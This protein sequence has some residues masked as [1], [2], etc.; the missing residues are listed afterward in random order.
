[1]EALRE[2][3]CKESASAESEWANATK[4]LADARVKDDDLRAEVKWRTAEKQAA[5]RAVAEAESRHAIAAAAL[6][7]AE[8]QSITAAAVVAQ[9]QGLLGQL[10]DHEAQLLQQ[11]KLAAEARQEAQETK[12]H[13]K[14]RQQQLEEARQELRSVRSQHEHEKYMHQALQE[15]HRKLTEDLKTF[16]ELKQQEELKR[17]QLELIKTDKEL[18]QKEVKSQHT[19]KEILAEKCNRAEVQ[20]LEMKSRED[21]M[22]G[23]LAVLQEALRTA[24][25]DA[26]ALRARLESRDF[27]AEEAGRP[28][29]LPDQHQPAPKSLHTPDPPNSKLLVK[30]AISPVAVEMGDG[31]AVD[32]HFPDTQIEEAA[33]KRPRKSEDQ[34]MGDGAKLL[35]EAFSPSLQPLSNLS[36]VATTPPTP[37]PL[38]TEDWRRSGFMS[39]AETAKPGKLAENARA[40]KRSKEE[41]ER[42]AHSMFSTK[43]QPRQLRAPPLKLYPAHIE[44]VLSNWD[45][46]IAKYGHGDGRSAGLTERKPEALEALR[47]H[48]HAAPSGWQAVQNFLKASANESANESPT[49]MRCIVSRACAKR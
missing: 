30:G 44:Y 16:E 3:L 17:S 37:K 41:V 6:V 2:R 19:E 47:P 22:S 48:H 39:V 26:A 49:R 46:Y 5:E 29:G 1:M 13:L 43:P 20:L 15:Q 25:N 23:Q 24:Q 45:A 14:E 33:V 35:K 42:I 11:S 21:R 27:S 4:V 8:K 28:L 40:P 18:L 9:K 36:R 7:E 10:W 34:E 38:V 32:Q 31:D 12:A